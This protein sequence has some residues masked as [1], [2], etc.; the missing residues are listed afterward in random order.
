M[1]MRRNLLLIVIVILGLMAT[2]GLQ[3]CGLIGGDDEEAAEGETAEG[4]E[5]GVEGEMPAEP[6]MEGEM[7]A[8][9]GMEGEMPAEPGMGGPPPGEGAP[10]D[11]AAAPA[12]ADASQLVAEGMAAK[13][14]GD[15]VTAREK[16]EAAVAA[17]SQ[18]ADARWGLAWVYAEMADAGDQA[19]RQEAID[20]FEA[21]LELGG[22]QEQV[23]EATD[24][25]DRLR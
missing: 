23:A 2:L 8:E 11:G 17:D 14:D 7:P 20:E 6:G 19:M 1:M 16:F 10:V 25:L 12:G 13:H 21:F 22:T 24:A 4:A 3:G 9:P 5:P 15:Y 18:N